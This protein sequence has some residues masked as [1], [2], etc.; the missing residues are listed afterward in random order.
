MSDELWLQKMVTPSRL[1]DDPDGISD[2]RLGASYAIDP[3]TERR[4]R[5]SNSGAED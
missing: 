5:K 1:D 4:R 3:G 2:A